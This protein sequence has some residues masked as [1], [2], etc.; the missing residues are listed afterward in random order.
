LRNT[1]NVNEF[2]KYGGPELLL[3]YYSLPMLPFDFSVSNAFD[4]LSYVFRM[5]SDVVPMPFAN[6]IAKKVYESSRFIFTDLDMKKST[7]YD[8]I[9]ANGKCFD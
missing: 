5:I 9:E 6:L 8:Y 2:V 7:I 4:S 3:K 1:D